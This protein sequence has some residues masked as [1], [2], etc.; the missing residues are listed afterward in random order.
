MKNGALRER[1]K[2]NLDGSGTTNWFVVYNA[3]DPVEA[4][5]IKGLLE[6]NGIR[7]AIDERKII[8]QEVLPS[9]ASGSI[10]VMVSKENLPAALKLIREIEK[11]LETDG[12]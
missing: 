7:C 4:D 6:S 12:E 1:R 5:I 11:Q 3:G 8:T 2:I 10:P 9:M